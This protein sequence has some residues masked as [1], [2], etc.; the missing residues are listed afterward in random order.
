[1]KKVMPMLISENQGGFLSNKNIFSNM[2]L[3]QEAIHSS[4]EANNSGM[5]IKLDLANVGCFEVRPGF[6]HTM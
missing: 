6:T 3:V 5:A 4:F 2:I 1:M